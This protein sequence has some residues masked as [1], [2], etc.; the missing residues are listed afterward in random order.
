MSGLINIGLSG[1]NSAQIALNTT[2]HNITNANTPNFSRQRTLQ[3]TAL[4]QFTGAG[5]TGQGSRIGNIERQYDAFLTAQLSSVTSRLEYSTAYRNAMSQVENLLGDANAG[6]ATA[7]SEFFRGVNDVAN[8]PTSIPARQAMISLGQSLTGRV[9]SVNGRLEEL[10]SL[11]EGQLRE[12]VTT[13][14]SFGRELAELNQQILAS[15]GSD[16]RI[17]PNDL[18]DRRDFL[19]SEL[20]KFVNVSSYTDDNGNLNVFMGSGQTLVLGTSSIPLSIIPDQ[21][22]PRRGLIAT[23]SGPSATLLPES[24][25]SGGRLGGLLA[26]RAESLDRVQNELGAIVETLAGE[27]NTLHQQGFGL[28]GSTGQSFFTIGDNS[29]ARRILETFSMGLTDPRAVAAA[30]AANAPGNN[31]NALALAGLQT[32]KLMDGNTATLNSKYS[33]LVSFVGNRGR[34]LEVAMRAQ[35]VQ[36]DQAFAARENISGVNLDEE[37]ANLIRFQQSYQAAARVVS[38]AGTLFDEVI[39]LVRR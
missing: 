19:V 22:D 13:I 4:P 10:R 29:S 7:M 39:G 23:G 26:F 36:R 27:F 33:Q 16:P 3:S 17:Q 32:Q 8:N 5:F 25:I 20:S 34:E 35:T 1:L 37:A 14:N 38:I 15:S 28:D 2:S 11:N 31:E 18:L 21:N 24:L 12:T 6:L 9:Q 30:S